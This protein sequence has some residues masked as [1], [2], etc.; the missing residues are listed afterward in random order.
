MVPTKDRNHYANFIK[1]ETEG[2]LI[3]C[4]EGTQRQLRLA[5]LKLTDVTHLLITHLHGDHV[6][7]VP[8]LM[9]SLASGDYTHT[10][11][12]FGPKGTERFI[13]N[14][15]KTFIFDKRIEYEV[16]DIEKDGTIFTTKTLKVK[17]IHLDH[18]V[19]S[20]GYRII[21][22]DRRKM[23]MGYLKKHNIPEGPLMG[24][25]QRGKDI[26]VDGMTILV[27]KATTIV[28]GRVLGIIPDTMICKG[29]YDI[30]KDA[31]LLLSESTYTSEYEDKAT[32]HKH[33]TALQAAQI[34]SQAGAKRLVL[35]H[36]SARYKTTEDIEKD[37]KLAFEHTVCAA[38]LMKFK[39]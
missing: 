20:V 6:L 18:S 2:L 1:H 27:D 13:A 30:A 35:T 36:F 19:T 29:C 7:G 16:K 15:L 12:I 23:N 31:D 34:A 24:E 4:G 32:E 37:A 17:A 33:L 3:D 25:L 14:L 22:N 26:V 9:Q 28:K 5:D 8:G 10:L 39:V 21:E 38:D 11:K